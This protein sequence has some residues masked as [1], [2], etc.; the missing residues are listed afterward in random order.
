MLVLESHFG[1]SLIFVR[2]YVPTDKVEIYKSNSGVCREECSLD[3]RSYFRHNNLIISRILF[4]PLIFF[5]KFIILW[6]KNIGLRICSARDTCSQFWKIRCAHL[7]RVFQWPCSVP[8]MTKRKFIGR[9]DENS[10]KTVFHKLF[11]PVQSVYLC[12]I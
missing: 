6:R 8:E 1:I 11:F 9:V 12:F 7:R 10:S 4:C 2:M 3:Y 5:F